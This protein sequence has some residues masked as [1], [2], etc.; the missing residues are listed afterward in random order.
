MARLMKLIDEQLNKNL[1]TT[2]RDVFYRDVNIFRDQSISDN[3]IEDL[4]VMLGV[5]RASLNVV[6]ST[7]GIVVGR[8]NFKESGD[9]IDCTNHLLIAKE[10]HFCFSNTESD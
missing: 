10:N 2:K 8:I 7:K 6:A 3:L 1:H 9:L 4:A 5:T